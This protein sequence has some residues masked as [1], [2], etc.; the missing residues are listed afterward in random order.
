ME[1]RRSRCDTFIRDFDAGPASIGFVIVGPPYSARCKCARRG[2]ADILDVAADQHD[3]FG[4]LD[5]DVGAGQRGN[6][7]EERQSIE[8]NHRN[9]CRP[10]KDPD[11]SMYALFPAITA[12]ESAKVYF[13]LRSLSLIET[14]TSLVSP[15]HRSDGNPLTSYCL[16]HRT[17]TLPKVESRYSWFH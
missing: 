5:L 3:P 4:N 13:Y 6:Q 9:R 10:T 15:Q 8:V 1:Q 7:P 16:P 2:Q 14:R 12:D 11:D 17:P